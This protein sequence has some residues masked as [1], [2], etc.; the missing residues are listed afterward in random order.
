[1]AT[2]FAQG[3]KV[4]AALE[5][6]GIVPA[7]WFWRWHPGAKGGVFPP[8]VGLNGSFEADV[9]DFGSMPQG[10]VNADYCE[11]QLQTVWRDERTGRFARPEVA[12][13]ASAEATGP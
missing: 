5:N 3:V 7:G 10:D 6:V 11:C 13:A 1:M 12:V 8:H 9:L 2:G 4:T